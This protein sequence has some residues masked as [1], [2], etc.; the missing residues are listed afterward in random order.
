VAQGIKAT[1][2]PHRVY[3]LCVEHSNRL[4]AALAECERAA[5]IRANQLL[6]LLSILTQLARSSA[7]FKALHYFCNQTEFFSSFSKSQLYQLVSRLHSLINSTFY[8]NAQRST[9]EQDIDAI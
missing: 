5:K 3:M 7:C 1:R 6:F 2:H 8:F 9:K 4:I